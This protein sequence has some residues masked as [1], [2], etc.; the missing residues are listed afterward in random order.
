MAA[1]L[2]PPTSLDECFFFNSLVVGLPCSLIFWQFWLFS[3]FKFVVVLL[4]VVQGGT[5][6]LPTP[7]SWPEDHEAHFKYQSFMQ[8]MDHIEWWICKIVIELKNFY[9]LVAL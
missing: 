5:V 2:R 7:L 8:S 1:C 3:V 4:L 6:Y 9:D